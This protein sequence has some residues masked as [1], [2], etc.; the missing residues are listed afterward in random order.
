[1]K[2]PCT[3]LVAVGLAKSANCQNNKQFVQKELGLLSG[4]GLREQD[5]YGP[6]WVDLDHTLGRTCNSCITHGERF[7]SG[8]TGP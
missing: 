8:G 6:L 5:Y 7:N 2:E 4:G 3:S 1:M